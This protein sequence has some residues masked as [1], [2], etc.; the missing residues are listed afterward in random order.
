MPKRAKK[1]RKK[2][3]KDYLRLVNLDWK[4]KKGTHVRVWDKNKNYY[5]YYKYKG[6]PFLS[7]YQELPEETRQS[8]KSPTQII[9]AKQKIYKGIQAKEGRQFLKESKIKFKKQR[10]IQ[11]LFKKGQITLRTTNEELQNNPGTIYRKLISPLIDTSTQ[12]GK[13]ALEI[14]TNNRDNLDKMKH[15]FFYYLEPKGD[16]GTT[17]EERKSTRK[18]P[19]ANTRIANKTIDEVISILQQLENGTE[20]WWESNI[21]HPMD[22]L[23]N[24]G[25]L[26]NYKPEVG[27][28]EKGIQENMP[29]EIIFTVGGGTE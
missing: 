29:I 18:G 19:L 10:S 2:K 13:E 3:K 28:N 20:Y 1:T 22:D 6:E 14:F 17:E 7:L 16:I 27:H 26:E 15:R 24:N 9:K 4:R 5:H 25:L 23:I 8:K 21:F 12:A 11:Q